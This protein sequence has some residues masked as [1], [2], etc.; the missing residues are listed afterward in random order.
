[1]SPARDAG[2][3]LVAAGFDEKAAPYVEALLAVGV[4]AERIVVLTPGMRP[5]VPAEIVAGAAGLVLS[6]GADIAPERYGEAPR[7]HARL[8]VYPERDAMEWELLAAA[9]ERRLPVWGVCRGLQVVNVFLGGTLWQDIPTQLPGPVPH[10]VAT[11]PDTLAHTVH[12]AAPDTALAERLSRETPVVNSRHHQAVKDLAPGL[13]TAALSPDGLVEAFELAD[14]RE[15]GWWVRAVQWHPE[16]LV[17]MAL[18]RA[19][20]ADFVRATEEA[21]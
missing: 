14:G 11:T 9:E 20:W 13:S 19:L 1:M 4:P 16:N 5:G 10:E 21:A 3:I 7:P 15:R 18:H 6:G 12:P 8:E 2:R 17:A